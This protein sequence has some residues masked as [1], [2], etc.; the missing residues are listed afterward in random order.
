MKQL[1]GMETR[2]LAFFSALVEE[3]QKAR[4]RNMELV[5]F[6]ESRKKVVFQEATGRQRGYKGFVFERILKGD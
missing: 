2:A 6:L 1:Q 5:L 4:R 3:F